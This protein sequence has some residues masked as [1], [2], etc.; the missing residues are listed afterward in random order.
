[1]ADNNLIK[2]VLATDPNPVM[3]STFA[4]PS[5]AT[6]TL[7]Y[8]KEKDPAASWPIDC[9][10]LRISIPTGR[11]ATALTG[12]PQR[13]N[14]S[15]GVVIDGTGKKWNIARDSTDPNRTEYTLVPDDDATFDG[16]WQLDVKLS[17]IE[18]NGAVGPV[19]IVVGERTKTAGGDWT[20]REGRVEVVKRDDVFF[21]HS[22]RPEKTIIAR[23]EKVKLHWEGSTNAEYT[24]YYRDQEGDQCP[25]LTNPGGTW[26]SP[27]LVEATNFTLKATLGEKD[28]YQ[29]T[30]V[31]VAEPDIRVHTL[32]VAD[33]VVSNLVV[34]TAKALTIR[35]LSGAGSPIKVTNSLDQ[36]DTSASIIT[37]TGGLTAKGNVSAVGDGKVVRIRE[38]QGPSGEELVIKN[39]LQTDGVTVQGDLTAIASGKKVRIRDLRGPSRQPLVIN[40]HTELR[41]NT[42]LTVTGTGKLK[43]IKAEFTGGVTVT[44]DGSLSVAGLLSATGKT[45]MVGDVQSFGLTWNTTKKFTAPTSGLAIGVVQCTGASRNPMVKLVSGG[46]SVEATARKH[47]SPAA[48]AF[49][50]TV[51]P[52]KKGAACYV[53]FVDSGGDDDSDYKYA[54]L[55][56][57]PFG[58]G[59]ISLAPALADEGVADEHDAVEV[60]PAD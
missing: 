42:D 56:W 1:M 2:P 18:V 23:G 21:L 46:K 37:G 15:T 31:R 32:G 49:A 6:L 33:K 9:S 3:V 60:E 58:A 7:V 27:P 50:T 29:T 25:K 52:V 53:D 55:M 11:Q 14:P 17:G 34:D 26:T 24:M 47:N 8:G 41:D 10:E 36:S 5:Y 44:K 40:S 54:W 12:D 13:I 59:S 39:G 48:T 51:L 57:I 28:L 45:S 38:L 22:L 30:H 4:E 35:T 20:E 16:T 19:S 43:A